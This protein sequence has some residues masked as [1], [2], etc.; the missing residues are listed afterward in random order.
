MIYALREKA[1]SALCAPTPR[2]WDA[3]CYRHAA[4]RI[5][6][7]DAGFPIIP[8]WWLLTALLA[9]WQYAEEK[10]AKWVVYREEAYARPRSRAARLEIGNSK[11]LLPDDRTA[12]QSWSTWK[13]PKGRGVPS[14]WYANTY[15]KLRDLDFKPAG[16]CICG[17]A[18]QKAPYILF[19]CNLGE[20]SVYWDQ[21]KST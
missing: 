18:T 2:A 5:I 21:K 6:V 11:G 4:I 10:R 17:A 14:S 20:H 3:F 13:C 16:E 1:L 9:I 12:G 15:P 8:F 19:E 7:Y